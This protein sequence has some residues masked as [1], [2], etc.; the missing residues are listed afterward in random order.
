[1]HLRHQSRSASRGVTLIEVLVAM[2][3]MSI[4]MLGIAG[5]Q[6]ATTKFQ[7]GSR[8]RGLMAPLLSDIA[9]RVRSNSEEAGSSAATG[10]GSAYPSAYVLSDSWATQQSATLSIATNCETGSTSCSTSDRATFD[11]TAWRQRVRAAMP[12]GAALLEG[13]R[14]NGFRVTFMW[15]DKQLTDKGNASDSVLVKSPVCSAAAETAG[16]NRMGQQNCCPEEVSAPEGVRC[17]R[18]SFIP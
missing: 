4:G 17:N 5:L 15:F 3:V 10:A 6:A 1:M 11:M 2:V 18:F 7:Q 12:Q 14:T 13:D 8:V 9:N 16:S